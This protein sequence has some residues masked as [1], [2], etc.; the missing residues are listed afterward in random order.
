L[1]INISYEIYSIVTKS[2]DLKVKVV[3]EKEEQVK[4]RKKGN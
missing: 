4:K 2:E 3:K 1:K